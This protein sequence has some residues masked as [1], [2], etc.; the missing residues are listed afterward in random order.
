MVLGRAAAIAD[1]YARGQYAFNGASVEVGERPYRH[2]KF[3]KLPEEEEALWCLLA[4]HIY[5]GGPGQVVGYRHFKELDDHHPLN[6]A[7][8]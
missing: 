4:C 8:L 6:S 7:S 5:V 2:V 3:S 1:H